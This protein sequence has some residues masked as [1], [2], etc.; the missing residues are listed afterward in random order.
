MSESCEIAGINLSPSSSSY[1]SM[2]TCVHNCSL[3]QTLNTKKYQLFKFM[4]NNNRV[5]GGCLQTRP[6]S[7]FQWAWQVNTS[8]IFYGKQ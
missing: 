3:Q 6:M 1:I 5:Y 8:L 2:M 7:H 4:P